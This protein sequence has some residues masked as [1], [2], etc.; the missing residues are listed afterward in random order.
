V[1]RGDT[2][3]RWQT[4][5]TAAAGLIVV[6]VIIDIALVERNRTLQ[7]EVNGRAQFI[8]QSVQL[9]ALNREIVAAI[10]NLAVRNNDDALKTVLTQHGITFNPTPASSSPT[11][12]GQLQPAAPSAG[13][14]QRGT[15]R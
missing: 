1:R 2:L 7:A 13:N 5:V 4:W 15:R 8:Q 9:D 10:A 12:G 6:L 14:G 11:S 3:G